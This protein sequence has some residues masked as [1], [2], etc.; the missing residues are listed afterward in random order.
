MRALLQECQNVID[1]VCFRGS[2]RTLTHVFTQ[3]RNDCCTHVMRFVPSALF[4]LYLHSVLADEGLDKLLTQVAK[5]TES[6]IADPN[7]QHSGADFTFLDSTVRY[8]ALIAFAVCVM[9]GRGRI[10]PAFL[11]AIDFVYVGDAYACGEKKG[12]VVNG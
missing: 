12:C 10:V 8:M 6:M 3:I 5:H 4:C 1:G 7:P 11:D 2:S 9:Y